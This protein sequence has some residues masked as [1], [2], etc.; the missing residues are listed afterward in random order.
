MELHFRSNSAYLSFLV[1]KSLGLKVIVLLIVSFFFSTNSLISQGLLDKKIDFSIQNQTIPDG[2]WKL[3]EEGSIEIAF[4][5]NY[6]SDKKYS[7]NF[8]Q[9][10]IRFI[11]N[12]MLAES[13]TTFSLI[14][15]QLII[16]KKPNK[17]ITLSG[18]IEDSESGERFIGANI[19]ERNSGKG[20][21]SNEYGFFSLTLTEGLQNLWISYLGYEPHTIKFEASEN[22]HFKIELKSNLTLAEIVVTGKDS[23]Y[24]GS[25]AFF[26]GDF[27]L[28]EGIENLPTL[29]GEVDILRILQQLPGV[30]SGTDGFGGLHV[31]GGN[32]DQNLIL[33]DGVPIYNPYHALGMYSIFDHKIIRKVRYFRGHFPARYGG[34]ISSV[35]DVRTKEGN[36]KQIHA[37]AKIGLIA[38]KLAIEGPLL[39]NKAAFFVSARRSH[40]DPFLKNYSEKSRT[41]NNEKG[42]YNYYFGEVIAKINYS[43]SIRNKFY[44]SFYKGKDDF[45]NENEYETE[46]FNFEYQI[47]EKQ[48]LDW[49][50]TLGVYRWN[51]QIN[52]KIF[53]NLTATFSQFIFNSNERINQRL[54]DDQAFILYIPAQSAYRSKIENV[55]LKLDFDYVPNPKHYFRTGITASRNQFAPGIFT[56]ADSLQIDFEQELPDSLVNPP[57]TKAIELNVYFED[58]WKP[59]PNLTIHSGLFFSSFN[60][61]QKNYLQVEPRFSLDWQIIKPLRFNLS[62]NKM[63]QYLH[64]LTRSDSGFPND[65]W[66]S[67]T[68]KIRPQQS[69]VFD[70][71]L[72]WS[73]ATDWSVSTSVYYKKMNNLINYSEDASFSP[74]STGVSANTNNI[75]AKNWEDN[76]T[77][78][79]GSSKGIECLIKKEA[80]KSTGWISYTLSETNRQFDAIN[81]GETYPFR[82]DLRHV[83]NIAYSYQ[84]NKNWCLASTWNYSSG[85]HISLPLRN[86]QYIRQDQLPDYVYLFS[87]TCQ[88]PNGCFC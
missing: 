54:F 25:Q 84:L 56:S 66:V 61:D 11:I 77:V 75:N 13:N 58:E 40:I 37:N 29:G 55:S 80:G 73:F 19:F 51:H 60:V 5:N 72:N 16:F 81:N 78:G 32:A 18:Y 85:S 6:F 46:D 8:Q 31:R 47:D 65:L 24:N 68:G 34:R 52:E 88:S 62:A 2:L 79:K 42:F 57:S 45:H 14:G 35:V 39:K 49:G 67:S 7:F 17:K 1:P 71:G 15:N 63:N 33:L 70:V 48:N 76:V 26:D 28:T 74:F 10:P 9:Q 36:N 3:S 69:W 30:Q 53:S 50:N 27:S 4:S 59:L 22:K 64:L 44:L 87:I 12:Q 41:E 20:T 23:L 83:F 38:S 86:W 21:T 43:A 82:F